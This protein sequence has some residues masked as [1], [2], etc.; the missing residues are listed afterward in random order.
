M[1]H[2][3][4]VLPVNNEK[5]SIEIV[6]KEWKY[7]LDKQNIKY[8]FVVCEDGSVDGTKELLVRLQ[9]KYPLVLNQ[10]QK[11]RGYGGAVIDGITSSNSEYILCVDSDGQCNPKDFNAFW[12]NKDR[13]HVLIGWRKKRADPLQRKIF[14]LFFKIIF[15]SLFPAPIHDPSAPYVLFK[16]QTIIPHISYLR[17]LR[18]GFWW[19]FIGM[20]IK[21]N[22]SVYE[23]PIKHRKRIKGETKVYK[24][25]KIFEIFIRN[26]LGLLK[27]KLLK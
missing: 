16:K 17:Y 5:G 6:F 10:K 7:E 2:I 27:L 26:F 3:N 24:I 22:L 1:E 23:I 4:V 11:R 15:V 9:K 12:K 19:G 21:K 18:E 20:C 25:E 8:S 14:S 13:A